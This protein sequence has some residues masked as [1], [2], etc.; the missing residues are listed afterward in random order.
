MTSS[1]ARAQGSLPVLS[2]R[3]S[4]R[5]GPMNLSIPSRSVG[6]D[7]ESRNRHGVPSRPI[8]G[9]HC[10]SGYSAGQNDSPRGASRAEKEQATSSR[11]AVAFGTHQKRRPPEGGHAARCRGR[12][13]ELRR[14]GPRVERVAFRFYALSQHVY[15]GTQAIRFAHQTRNPIR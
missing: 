6:L 2:A 9:L 5:R 10:D 12:R 4:R 7:R 15:S 11:V 1:L 13:G 8:S 14:E 3:Q